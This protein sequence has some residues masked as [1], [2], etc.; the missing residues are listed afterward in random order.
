M[1]NEITP[2]NHGDCESQQEDAQIRDALSG[3][4]DLKIPPDLRA[5]N[6]RNIEDAL[7]ET[8]GGRPRQGASWWHKRLSV[9]FPVAAGFMLVLGLSLILGLLQRQTVN[10]SVPEDTKSVKSM[11]SSEVRPHY[12]EASVY[13]AGM[14][15]IEKERGYR[16]F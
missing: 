8:R 7:V 4:K 15:F 2:E 13:V 5:S 14:G 3:L 6:Q 9:P 1:A 16:F 11:M 10:L 12:Y